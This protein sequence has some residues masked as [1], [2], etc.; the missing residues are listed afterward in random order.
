M[1]VFAFT[2]GSLGDI[3]ATISLTTQVVKVL[4]D[5]RN[6]TRECDTLAMEVRS[7]QQVLILTNVALKRYEST[8][9]GETLVH[10]I[11]PEVA[12]CHLV[13]QQLSHKVE[14]CRQALTSTTISTLWKRVVWAASGEALSVSAKLSGH[15]MKLALLL[16][17]LNS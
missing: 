6:I 1:P 16:M 11:L 15:R 10:C 7:L 13:L 4:Y 3:V 5:H 2:A 17:S 8:P 14:S 12:Q 9:L